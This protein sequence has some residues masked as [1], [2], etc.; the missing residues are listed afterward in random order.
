MPII[1]KCLFIL[2]EE[3]HLQVSSDPRDV[4]VRRWLMRPIR[5]GIGSSSNIIWPKRCMGAEMA[6]EGSTR[7]K[8]SRTLWTF[9]WYTC[10]SESTKGET[11]QE[12][13]E[14]LEEYR[15]VIGCCQYFPH[16]P[17][18]LR[19]TDKSQS[20]NSWFAING[21]RDLYLEG[22]TCFKT[23]RTPGFMQTPNLFLKFF[24][25]VS[26]TQITFIHGLVLQR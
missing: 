6:N 13:E 26:T 9:V 3:D 25:N 19:L 15:P 22:N 16:I 17:I 4:W 20:T 8:D 24:K 5:C 23:S 21:Q 7:P 1:V 14:N 18:S 12:F 11:Y 2:V 10:S